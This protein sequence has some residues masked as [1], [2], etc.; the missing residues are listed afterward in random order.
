M[1]ATADRCAG[2]RPGNIRLIATT[3]TPYE[4]AAYYNAAG[5]AMRQAFNTYVRTSGIF[6]GFIDFDRVMRDPAHPARFLPTYDSRRPPA[7]QRPR[8]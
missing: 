7:P 6:D 4:G 5:D 3:L 2:P 1:G 8:L